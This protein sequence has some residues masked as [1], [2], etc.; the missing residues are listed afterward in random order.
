MTNAQECEWHWHPI[1]HTS[2]HKQPHASELYSCKH[3]NVSVYRPAHILI[4]DHIRHTHRHKDIDM[5]TSL[6]NL[7]R[8]AYECFDLKCYNAADELRDLASQWIVE[9]DL[10]FE[11][12]SYSNAD[13]Y[14][15][16]RALHFELIKINSA[17]AHSKLDVEF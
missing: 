17:S 13:L 12:K 8:I 14:Y 3:E 4:M 2:T 9:S 6:D 16:L 11:L 1:A 15:M 5:R 10:D 7:A